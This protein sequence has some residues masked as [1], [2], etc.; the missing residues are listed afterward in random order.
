MI[1]AYQSTP[2]I[3]AAESKAKLCLQFVDA[4]DADDASEYDD[5]MSRM[6]SVS[7]HSAYSSDDDMS[8]VHQLSGSPG[9]PTEVSCSLVAHG[10][11]IYMLG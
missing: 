10:L 2:N 9:R 3:S 7:M 8:P 6:G 1:T 4:N 11:P 5:A